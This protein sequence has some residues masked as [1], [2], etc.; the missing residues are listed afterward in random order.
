M[1]K[2]EDIRKGDV[3]LFEYIPTAAGTIHGV[4][5]DVYFDRKEMEVLPS[6]FHY[7]TDCHI[8]DVEAVYRLVQ[9]SV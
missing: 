3:V 9:P 8:S 2:I 4:V 6:D 1:Y 5:T 7:S